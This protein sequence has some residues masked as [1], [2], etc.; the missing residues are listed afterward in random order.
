MH[1]QEAGGLGRRHGLIEVCSLLDAGPL[2]AVVD[3]P[4][5]ARLVPG[6]IALIQRGGCSFALKTANAQTAGAAAIIFFNQGDTP[7]RSVTL[8]NV[9]A[10]PPAG[11]SRYDDHHRAD[12]RELRGG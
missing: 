6:R 1:D 2:R 7:A 9:T 11:L 4:E 10:V 8:S 3:P 12:R 5:A